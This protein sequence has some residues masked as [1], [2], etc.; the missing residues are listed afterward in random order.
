[1]KFR[2]KKRYVL[3]YFFF[4]FHKFQG[5]YTKFQAISRVQ[6]AKNILY[7]YKMININ[8]MI[9]NVCGTFQLQRKYQLYVN[10]T[11]VLVCLNFFITCKLLITICHTPF[12]VDKKTPDHL[13]GQ[14]GQTWYLHWFSGRPFLTSTLSQFD[15]NPGATCLCRYTT[16][17]QTN[18]PWH[19]CRLHIHISLRYILSFTTW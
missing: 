13:P 19:T 15:N 18:Q 12:F 2:E 7:L 3:V 5:F 14:G 16:C 10:C 9:S 6:G 17:D 11:G 8:S 4:I 1:M